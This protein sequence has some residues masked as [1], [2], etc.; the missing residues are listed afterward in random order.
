MGKLYRLILVCMVTTSFAIHANAQWNEDL[1]ENLL[2]S[3]LGK[4]GQDLVQTGKTSDNKVFIAW[5]SWENA[6]AYVKLQLLDKDGNALL[7]SGGMYVCKYPTPT[8]SSGFGF[9]VSADDCALIV[10]SDVRNGTDDGWKPY[11]YKINQRGEHVWSSEG[12]SLLSE[13]G[14]SGID[15]HVCTTSDHN[16]V[17]GFRQLSNQ[18]G[19]AKLMVTKLLANGSRAWGAN[20][21][22]ADV[23][24]IFSVIPSVNDAFFVPYF[25]AFS[26]SV[27]DYA[28]KKYTANGEEAWPEKVYI[29]ESG[30]VKVQVEPSWVVDGNGGFVVGYRYTDGNINHGAVQKFTSDG[31]YTLEDYELA[32][33]PVVCIAADRSVYAACVNSSY[34]NASLSLTKYSETGEVVW[35][36]DDLAEGSSWQYNL[37][38]VVAVDNEL[39]VIYRNSPTVDGMLIEYSKV[40]P[41]GETIARHLPVSTSP[42]NKD[43]GSLAVT[44]EQI[45]LAWTEKK[46][47]TGGKIYAQNIVREGDTG[48][49]SQTG[50]NEMEFCIY[51]NTEGELNVEIRARE[52][53][54]ATVSLTAS[55]GSR[56]AIWPVS[57]IQGENSFSGLAGNLNPG[58]YL[59]SVQTGSGCVSGKFIIK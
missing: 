20:V 8:F 30:M 21:K 31:D 34:G 41:D 45:V 43:R 28:V 46:S 7:G 22:V 3:E 15:P 49:L 35:R 23:N 29:D 33:L 27:G 26:T 9:T 2:V 44:D 13:P 52:G 17:V 55:D 57:L 5:I 1:S 50:G 39:F 40:S 36:N 54:S 25:E 32:D 37:Y 47:E 48:I 56:V 51:Q 16:I 53:G 4:G 38:G 6:S 18:G 42:L 19:G 59:L 58:L 14:L 24:A 12:I 11:L 10:N